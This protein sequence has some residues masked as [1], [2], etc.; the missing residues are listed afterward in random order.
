MQRGHATIPSGTLG[1]LT[2]AEVDAA[3]ELT[4]L[5]RLLELGERW[6]GLAV[7]AGF[8]ERFYRLNSLPHQLLALY[9]GLDPTD[10]D[11]D[12]V[13]EAEPAATAMVA[14][15]Y[16]LDESVDL[17]YDSLD[18]DGPTTVRR[19]GRE[20]G[21]AATGRRAVLLAVKRLYRDDWTAAAVMERLAATAR[22]GLEARPVLITPAPERV[23]PAL[24][25]R[26]GALLGQAVR[27]WV[28][29]EGALVRLAPA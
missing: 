2:R 14:Q 1:H 18:G 8:E 9:R 3:W 5:S 24:A 17:L 6:R 4:A 7:P 27:A 16:L 20:G 29:G 11:E 23:D 12:I 19:A 25:T 15:H 21:H 10:P 13:E 22:L 28:D 26:L